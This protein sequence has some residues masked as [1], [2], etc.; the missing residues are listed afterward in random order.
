[1]SAL[2]EEKAALRV[3]MREALKKMSE[4]S[5][6]RQSASACMNLA[7]VSAFQGA[8]TVL[9]YN[10]LPFECDP[11]A[12][13]RLAREAKKRIVYPMCAEGNTLLLYAPRGEGAFVSRSYGILEP[14]PAFSDAVSLAEIDFIV[15]PGLAFDRRGGR[16]GR[17]AGYYDR[18][19]RDSRA[20]K[21][22]FAFFEQL[23]LRVPME[24]FDVKMDCVAAGKGIYCE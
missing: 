8:K 11:A 17:G 24:P 18:L 15:V 10:A 1:M 6:R 9:L 14:D 23:V 22:G 13:A 5:R 12:L 3:K 7:G 20:Y 4:E 2:F 19:L 16:L 21:A